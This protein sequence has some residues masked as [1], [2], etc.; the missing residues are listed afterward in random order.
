MEG[1]GCLEEWD[2]SDYMMEE[3]QDVDSLVKTSKPSLHS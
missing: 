1:K 2:T 3:K